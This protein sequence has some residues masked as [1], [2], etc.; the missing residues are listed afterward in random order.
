MFTSI[1]LSISSIRKY[2]N[3]PFGEKFLVFEI[4]SE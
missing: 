1:Y 3:D 2:F 4:M